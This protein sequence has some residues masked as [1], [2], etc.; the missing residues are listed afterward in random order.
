MQEAK[1]QRRR[2]H[3]W[4]E[5]HRGREAE[6]KRAQEHKNI[7]REEHRSIE[8]EKKISRGIEEQKRREETKQCSREAKDLTMRKANPHR[9]KRRITEICFTLLEWEPQTHR[10]WV[11]WKPRLRRPWGQL[12]IHIH[13]VRE[14][15]WQRT[16]ESM[17]MIIPPSDSPLP[18]VSALGYFFHSPFLDYLGC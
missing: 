10:V 2:E 14:G 16:I 7:G 15:C 6:E 18:T 17:S 12:Y 1:E 8:K 11:T 13:I 3:S 9:S 4:A 5:E